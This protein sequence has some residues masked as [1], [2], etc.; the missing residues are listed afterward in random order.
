YQGFTP[1]FATVPTA[2]PLAFA[3]AAGLHTYLSGLTPD[4]IAFANP[5][6]GTGGSHF[7]Y[8]QNRTVVGIPVQP[9]ILRSDVFVDSLLAGFTNPAT[10]NSDTLGKAIRAIN[11]NA[12]T[13][14]VGTNLTLGAVTIQL[15]QGGTTSTAGSLVWNNFPSGFTGFLY[16]QNRTT[17]G[18]GVSSSNW[19]A[20]SF[21][22]AG[23]FALNLGT[24]SWTMGGNNQPATCD[25]VTLATGK[26]CK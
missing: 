17:A 1:A 15:N 16:T 21:S 25:G 14:S 8:L 19:S 12:I 24:A 10:Y 9:V 11:T 2:S 13:N 4:T 18:P 5:G 3:P 20:V 22:G 7:Y 26:T 23:A 6:T